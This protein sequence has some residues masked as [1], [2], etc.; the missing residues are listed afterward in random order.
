MSSSVSTAAS[1]WSTSTAC[2]VL[3]TTYNKVHLLFYET[4]CLQQNLEEES[5]GLKS[6]QDH[7]IKESIAY[8]LE[9]SDSNA[10]TGIG[11]LQIAPADNDR[12]YVQK[13]RNVFSRVKK[14]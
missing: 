9:P 13:I 2:V 6:S 7:V 14:L 4:K 1:I 5:Q 10:K 12:G 11:F 8:R 3:L